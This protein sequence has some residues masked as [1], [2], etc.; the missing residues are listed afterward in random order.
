[1][2][3][4]YDSGEIDAYST[5]SAVIYENL[6]N[7]SDPDNH[8]I[9]DVEIDKIPVSLYFPENDSQLGDVIRWLTYVPIQAEEFGITSENINQFLAINT[10]DNPNNDSS[11]EIRRFLGLEGEL[12]ATLGLPNYFAVNIIRQV[13]NYAEIYHRHFPGLERGRNLLAR[14]GGLLYSPP[15][16]GTAI[17]DLEII[18]NDNRDV[19]QEVIERGFLRV[20]I[21]GQAPGFSQ[22]KENGELTGFDVDLGRAIAAAIFGDP[23]A[24][25]FI[26]QDNLERFTNVANGI[27]DISASQTTHNLVRDASFGV[28]YSPIYLYTGQGIMVRKNSGIYNLAMLNGRKIGVVANTTS[29]QNLEDE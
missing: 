28:D 17:P 6:A 4:A 5:D 25:E 2:V 20:G 27:V 7:L 19:L 12:G 8:Q 18:D 22:T 14:D 23:N 10:D 13:G 15:F 29:Q 9:L 26:Q 1:M 24:V 3:A 11:V 21:N 16:S